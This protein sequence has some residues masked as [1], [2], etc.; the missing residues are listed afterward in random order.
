MDEQRR[1]LKQHLL[2][3][4]A[5]LYNQ[6]LPPV[7]EDTAEDKK[8]YYNSLAKWAIVNKIIRAYYPGLRPSNGKLIKS[9]EVDI[10]TIKVKK[11][12]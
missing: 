5:S 4:E 8:L 11:I 2:E 1:S 6:I 10:K 3:A 7:V 9:K 12:E